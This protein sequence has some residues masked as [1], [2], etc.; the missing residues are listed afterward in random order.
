M[1]NLRTICLL[2]AASAFMLACSNS[3][4]NSQ[5][6]DTDMPEKLFKKFTNPDLSELTPLTMEELEAWL[7]AELG[8]LPLHSVHPGSLSGAGIN[9]IGGRYISGDKE[10]SL[11]V[12]DAAG[13]TA[14]PIAGG[15]FGQLEMAINGQRPLNEGEEVVTIGGIRAIQ[16]YQDDSYHHSFVHQGRLLIIVDATRFSKDEAEQVIK[17]LPMDKLI[18][19]LL[20]T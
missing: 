11:M 3:T 16:S 8:G 2:W 17:S 6:E 5:G 20:S 12:T 9:G 1:K 13:P 4:S 10:I 15:M 14:A 18:K 19:S 7:P